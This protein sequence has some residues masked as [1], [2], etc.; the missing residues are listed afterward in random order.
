MGGAVGTVAL[1]LLSDRMRHIPRSA[2]AFAS[3]VLLA[4]A[5]WLYLAVGGTSVAANFLAM[6]LVGALLFG[7]DALLSGAAAQDAGGPLAAAMAAGVVNGIGSLGGL[8]QEVV[9]RGVSKAFGWDALFYV[10]VA[11][12]ALSAVALV[13][14]LRR[15]ADAPA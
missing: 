15:R 2:F 6:A 7:P 1:G 4:G 13:P 11:L 12:S 9:T 8:L 5:F 10:F 14:T 3:L